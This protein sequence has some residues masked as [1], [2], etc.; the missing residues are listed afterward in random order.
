MKLTTALSLLLLIVSQVQ[1]QCLT[2]N[3][4]LQTSESA[5]A[6]ERLRDS[7]FDFALESLKKIADIETQD[8]IF[9]SPHSLHEA[10]SVAYFGARGETETA[11]KKALH[12]PDDLSKNDVQR[13]YT[14][15]KDTLLKRK[16]SRS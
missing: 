6:I 8:N 5:N 2:E 1:C 3:D 14:F 15:E 9:F 13:S 7:R 10:L 11:L 4:S 12:V 16:V